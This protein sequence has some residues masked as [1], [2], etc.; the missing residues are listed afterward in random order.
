M[1]YQNPTPERKSRGAFSEA[2]GSVV[3]MEKIVQIVLVLPCAVL[4]GWGA[5]I[6]L[7]DH[8]HTSWMTLTGFVL[9]CIAGFSSVIKM[10]MQTVNEPARKSGGGTDSKG[11]VKNDPQ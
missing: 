1:A 2:I 7:D 9:G 4:I 11:P 8:F 5:G 3:Q 6:A 10:A